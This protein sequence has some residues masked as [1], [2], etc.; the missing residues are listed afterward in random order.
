MDTNHKGL[1]ETIESKIKMSGIRDDLTDEFVGEESIM[2]CPKKNMHPDF[3]IQFRSGMVTGFIRGEDCGPV[4]LTDGGEGVVLPACDWIGPEAFAD[5]SAIRSVQFRDRIYQM[6]SRV[7]AGCE[8]LIH[9]VLP[10]GTREIAM[11]TFRGCWSLKSVE[12]PETVKSIHNSAFERCALLRSFS[13]PKNLEAIQ[14]Y[15]FFGCTSL[16]E[17]VF[18]DALTVLEED[19]FANCIN[20]KRV[21]FGAGLQ[22]IKRCTFQNCNSLESIEIPEGVRCIEFGA[23]AGCRGLKHVKLPSTLVHLDPYAFYDCTALETVEHP[24]VSNF[25]AALCRTPYWKKLY[26]HYPYRPQVPMDLLNYVGGCIDGAALTSRGYTWFDP[27]MT[28]QIFPTKYPDVWEACIWRDVLGQNV[29]GNSFDCY[30]M[31][32]NLQPITGFESMKGVMYARMQ[33]NAR[34]CDKEIHDAWECV[35]KEM[36]MI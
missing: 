7:F 34:D 16:E 32:G 20:L 15:A 14:H 24:K 12:L 27:D 5:C 25:A 18:S 6:A 9:V 21:H 31:D 3:T 23:F 35:L 11:E 28:C 29:E 8:N 2:E 13:F 22:M 1:I 33:D 17:A 19:T 30:L 26:P 36:F 4:D 10:H